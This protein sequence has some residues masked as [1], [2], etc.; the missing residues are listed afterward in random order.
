MQGGPSQVDT[1]DP[2]PAFKKYERKAYS[3]HLQIGAN[4]HEIGYPMPSPFKFKR[5]GESGLKISELYPCVARFAD[6]LCVIRSM[7]QDTRHRAQ[8]KGRK[9]LTTNEDGIIDRGGR[10]EKEKSDS[11]VCPTRRCKPS[12]SERTGTV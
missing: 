6:E 8:G 1:F 11:Q 3:S 4:G 7:D 9:L 2:K 10:Q 5:H 12:F